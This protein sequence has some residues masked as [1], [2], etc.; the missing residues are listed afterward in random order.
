MMQKKGLCNT[1]VQELKEKISNQ[2]E[3][4]TNLEATKFLL[5]RE[6]KELIDKI[7]KVESDCRDKT[8]KLEQDQ[9]ELR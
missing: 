3:R 9:F 4:I 1:T 7:N 5:Q 8:L 6:N 2:E